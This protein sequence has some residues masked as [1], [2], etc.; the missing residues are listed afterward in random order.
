MSVIGFYSLVIQKGKTGLWVVRDHYLK[1][2]SLKNVWTSYSFG[3]G[4][5]WR[6]LNQALSNASSS[7]LLPQSIKQ[8]RKS[9]IAGVINK[10]P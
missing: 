7:I 3:E 9:L 1:I 2:A 10:K 4:K 8:Q 6:G 5:R